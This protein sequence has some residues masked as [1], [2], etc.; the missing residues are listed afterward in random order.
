MR[1]LIT[2]GLAIAL[3]APSLSSALRPQP[4]SVAPADEL[5]GRW[6]LVVQSGDTIYPSW[7]E[8][9][10]SGYRTLVGSF[11]SRFGS[12][13]PVANITLN[14]STFRFSLPPQW[15]QGTQELVIEG[16]LTNDKLAGWMTDALGNRQTWT[17]TR[18]PAM[19]RTSRPVWGAPVAIFNGRDLT[20]WEASGPENQWRVVNGILTNPRSGNN[21]ITKRTFGDFKLHVE[22]RVP[23]K[24]NS[25]LYLRGRH[26]VQIEDSYGLEPG[27]HHAGGVYGFLIPNE[28]AARRPGEWQTYDITLIGREITVVL[29][30]RSVIVAQN[31]PGI[32]GGALNSA[33]G[34][35]GPLMLQGDH[36]SVEFRKIILT[37]AR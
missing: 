24:G 5:L 12:A 13:R 19:R 31:I 34:E 17:A 20:G 18:A 21:L 2:V 10:K 36:T 6:D 33:E 4:V 37:P 23:D 27:S 22:F 30:G 29:N 35:P 26:E 25:G 9:R 8:V 11:V 3:S 14:N 16:T 32:T 1:L 28:N 7:L 15:E